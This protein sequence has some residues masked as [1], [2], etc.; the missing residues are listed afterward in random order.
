VRCF[1][2]RRRKEKCYEPNESENEKLGSE[3]RQVS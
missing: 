3:F 1:V 2:T